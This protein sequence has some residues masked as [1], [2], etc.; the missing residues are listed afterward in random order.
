MLIEAVPPRTQASETRP[1]QVDGAFLLSGTVTSTVLSINNP[2]D[3]LDVR[4]PALPV[5]VSPTAR[6]QAVS[7]RIVVRDCKVANRWTPAGRPFSITWRD[8]YGKEHMD[9]A[10]DFDRSMADSLVRYVDAVC[11][12]RA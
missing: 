1:L 9:S 5:T 8:E 3:S 10:G 7:L 2:D 11:G 4:T 6:F 12:N